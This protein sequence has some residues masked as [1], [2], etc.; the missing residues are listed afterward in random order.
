MFSV[1]EMCPERESTSLN[2]HP[3]LIACLI[4]VDCANECGDRWRVVLLPQ[5]NVAVT[6]D[7]QAP[8]NSASSLLHVKSI[9]LTSKTNFKNVV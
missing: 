4:N 8:T 5:W 2:I 3:V 9:C 6:S 7:P 1:P